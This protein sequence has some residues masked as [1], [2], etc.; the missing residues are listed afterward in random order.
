MESSEIPENRE[1]LSYKEAQIISGYGRTTLWAL[2]RAG[3]LPAAKCGRAVR[4]N[5]Q[6][7]EAYMWAQVSNSRGD[8][9]LSDEEP[10]GGR[11]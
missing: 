6:G 8:V 5:R 1:W 9:P 2:V 11:S 3:Q 4:I 7:L 10:K